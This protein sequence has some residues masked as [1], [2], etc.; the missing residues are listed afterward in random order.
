MITIARPDW[1]WN[2]WREIDRAQRDA[3]GIFTLPRRRP[4]AAYPPMNI[5]TGE[6]DVI[7]TAEIPGIEPADIDL[8]VTGDTLTIRGTRKAQEVKQGETWHRRE[9]GAGNF[10][11]TV[12]LPYNVDGNKVQADYVGG[13]LKIELPRAE[14]DKPRKIS[15]TPGK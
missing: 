4:L 15:V 12:Q 8:T 10:Y 3:S 1:G 9:R 7:I 6:E 11:R 13:V 2:P 14:A 5:H